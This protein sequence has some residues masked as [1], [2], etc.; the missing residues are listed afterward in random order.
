M[1]AEF[2]VDYV[3]KWRDSAV[4]FFRDPEARLRRIPVEWTDLAPLD[5]FVEV[6]E[7]RSPF[8]VEDLLRLAAL[9]D[10]LSP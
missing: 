7:G 6:S 3:Q 2:E 4:V 1:G 10:G 8:R 5:P 9:L